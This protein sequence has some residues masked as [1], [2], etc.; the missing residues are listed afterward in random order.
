[1][2]ETIWCSSP[3]KRVVAA[4]KSRGWAPM[5]KVTGSLSP[6]GAGLINPLEIGG[7]RDVGA[8]LIAIAQG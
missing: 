2:V 8:S 1:M 7:G 6:L 4:M 5:V 3:C